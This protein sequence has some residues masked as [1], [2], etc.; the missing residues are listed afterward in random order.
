MAIK[1]GRPVGYRADNTLAA[2]GVIKKL[3]FWKRTKLDAAAILKVQSIV[4]DTG[5]SVP[6]YA[7]V[8]KAHQDVRNARGAMV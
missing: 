4:H 3:R 2:Q 6:S 8:L 7:T 5:L 1:M